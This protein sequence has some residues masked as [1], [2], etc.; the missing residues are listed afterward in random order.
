VRTRAVVALLSC[1]CGCLLPD[2]QVQPADSGPAPGADAS[3]LPSQDDPAYAVPQRFQ[4]AQWPMPDAFMG[5]KATPSYQV[6]GKTVEDRVTHL[7]WQREPPGTYTSCTGRLLVKGDSCSWRQ[8]HAYCRT[9]DDDAAL[10]GDGWRLPTKIEL[11]S[12][13]DATSKHP[14]IDPMFLATTSA[15]FWTA[16]LYAG[17]SG[18]AWNVDFTDGLSDYFDIRDPLR[19]R[20]VRS[21]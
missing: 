1:V 2:V 18:Y 9:L 10:G 12:I 21:Q 5:A 16:S 14:A 4:F 8:A 6:A 20:C 15:G 3:A 11:E 17:E 13:V 7:V 19:V